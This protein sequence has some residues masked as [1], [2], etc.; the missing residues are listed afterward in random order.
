[1]LHNVDNTNVKVVSE[2]LRT[3]YCSG[4]DQSGKS[5][6]CR[7]CVKA[8]TLLLLRFVLGETSYGA[9]LSAKRK[10]DK[11]KTHHHIECGLFCM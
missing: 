11:K 3:R 6:Q 2:Y 7:E 10:Q 4:L 5:K 1:M 9:S 8:L